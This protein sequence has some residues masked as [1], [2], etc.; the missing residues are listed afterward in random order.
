MNY[1]VTSKKIRAAGRGRKTGPGRSLKSRAELEPVRP[2]CQRGK[3]SKFVISKLIS[4]FS[5]PAAMNRKIRK[6]FKRE[7]S[8]LEICAVYKCNMS[9]MLYHSSLAPEDHAETNM[10]DS[11][12]HVF[13]YLRMIYVIS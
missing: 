10:N 8:G 2:V 12:T 5:L 9:R 13:M 3:F 7:S 4:E 11:K 6:L 1:D